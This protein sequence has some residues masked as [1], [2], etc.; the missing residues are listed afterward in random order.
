MESDGQT[1][2]IRFEVDFRG[3]TAPRAP[4][5]LRVLP[6]FAPAADTWARTTVLSNICTSAAVGLV[7]ARS[8]KNTSNTPAW[9]SRQNRFQT[10]FQLPKYAGKARQVM[11]WTVK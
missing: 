3:E 9:L 1:F 2:E 6:P 11:L 7:S 4:E 8:W 10:L 5:R